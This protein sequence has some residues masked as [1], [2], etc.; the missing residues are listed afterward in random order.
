MIPSSQSEGC[1]YRKDQVVCVLSYQRKGILS[2]FQYMVPGLYDRLDH[3]SYQSNKNVPLLLK[4]DDLTILSRYEILDKRS[5]RAL[6]NIYN[7]QVFQKP[8]QESLHLMY[9]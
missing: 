2:H 9:Q 8:Q 1:I 3:H 4:Y 7:S 5:P 6:R